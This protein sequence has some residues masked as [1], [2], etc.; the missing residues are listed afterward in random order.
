LK[1][2]VSQTDAGCTDG[3]RQAQADAGRHRWAQQEGRHADTDGFRQ[4]EAG[5]DTGRR[6]KKQADTSAQDQ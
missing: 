4:A 2:Q 5:I 6:R 3:H 1:I